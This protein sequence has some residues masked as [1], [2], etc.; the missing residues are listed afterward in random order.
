[1]EEHNE[2]IFRITADISR[3]RD[4]VEMAKE[5]MGII[6]KSIPKEVPYKFLE[7]YYESALQLITAIMYS[8]GF[9]TL[10]HIKVIEYLKKYKEISSFELEILDKM[11]KF[12]NGIIY[13]G[14]KESGNFFINH[15]RDI[16][17]IINKLLAIAERKVK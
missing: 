6:I 9:K 11:R 15:E 13:Y 17:V 8:D 2:E 14:K 3:A 10:S 7:E 16:K 12:R 5:R 4:L 1:M